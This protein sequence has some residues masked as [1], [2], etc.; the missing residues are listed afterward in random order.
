MG[1]GTACLLAM[2]VALER[3]SVLVWTPSNILALFYLAGFGSVVAFSAY[4]YLIKKID[5]TV[6]IFSTLI[7]PIVALAL[8]RAFLHETVTPIAIL[9]IATILAGVVVAIIP[10]SENSKAT[11]RAASSPSI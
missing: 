2:S 9:G 7:I 5:A 1:L 10:G 8:G 11:S 4:Y 3:W 6:V